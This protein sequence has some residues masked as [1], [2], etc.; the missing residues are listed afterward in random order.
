MTTSQWTP[1]SPCSSQDPDTWFTEMQ[2]I[3]TL[4]SHGGED[5]SRSSSPS[6]TRQIGERQRV[7][8]KHF[9]SRTPLIREPSLPSLPPNATGVPTVKNRLYIKDLLAAA[10]SLVCFALSFIAVEN[11]EVSWRLGQGTNQLVVLGFLLSIMNLCLGSVAPTL[12]LLLEAKFGSSTLQNYDGILRNQVL[13]SKL[14]KV[15]RLV[16]G[17]ML[18]LPIFL[19]VAYK[20]FGGGESSKVFNPTAYTGNTSY[21]GMFAPPG[22]Q[23]LGERTG[24]MFFANSTLPFLVATSS[25]DDTGA[26]PPLPSQ[27]QSYGYNILLLNNESTAILDIPQPDYV[28][29]VQGSLAI[30]ES[31]RLTA[32]VLLEGSCNGNVL[33]YAKQLI[34]TD[35]NF[36]VGYYYMPSLIQFLGPFATTRN[37]SVWNYSYMATGIAAMLWSRI[38]AVEGAAG[39]AAEI[40]ATPFWVAGN[41]SVT[42]PTLEDVGLIYPINDKV[43]Y[44]RPT[45]RKSRWLYLVLG[46]QPLLLLVVILL[47]ISLYSTPLSNGFGMIAILSGIDRIS[48]DSLGGAALSG[49][50][51]TSMKLAIQTSEKDNTGSIGYQVMPTTNHLRNG[52]LETSVVYH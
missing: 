4:D 18:A 14:G 17:T 19:S 34:I 5:I 7:N 23:F 49:E 40:N 8:A 2:P 12:F 29:S 35:I 11:N 48:L 43:V 20:R 6:T 51:A 45:L 24:I 13:A 42:N 39:G 47:S 22:L 37:G 16:L 44:T 1:L 36:F 32:P 38:I 33:P 15:W 26:E 9:S 21:Y 50:L 27:E 30:G 28:S 25:T 46:T 52:K 31:W 41:N 3:P 10:I